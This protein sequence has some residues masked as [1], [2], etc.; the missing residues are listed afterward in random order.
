MARTTDPLWH[1]L[2]VAY[3][4]VP[5]IPGRILLADDTALREINDALQIAERT[6]D[7]ILGNAASRSTWRWCIAG[8]RAEGSYWDRSAA[9]A[10][11]SDIH[12]WKYRSSTCT[13]HVLAQALLARET[14][15]DLG[16]ASRGRPTCG[17][18]RY[19]RVA[20]GTTGPTGNSLIATARRPHRLALKDI[21]H[22]PR[23]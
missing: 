19:W 10:Y 18:W 8:I 13:P 6:S 21:S 11:K 1:V 3:K 20:A 23:P 4:Y 5:L 7:H 9:W 16:E 2:V 14:A 15:T 22:R 12:D 17:C